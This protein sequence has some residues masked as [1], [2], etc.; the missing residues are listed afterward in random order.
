MKEPGTLTKSPDATS[1][2]SSEDSVK[3]LAR[4]DSDWLSESHSPNQRKKRRPHLR[5]SKPSRSFKEQRDVKIHQNS[6]VRPT[7]QLQLC[8]LSL[9]FLGAKA[10]GIFVVVIC[11]SIVLFLSLED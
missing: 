9:Y 2:Q 3:A 5:A 1:P 4:E 11:M 8:F 10:R 6:D 7:K